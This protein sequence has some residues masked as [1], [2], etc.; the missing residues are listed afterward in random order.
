M[1]SRRRGAVKNKEGYPDPTAGKALANVRRQE[2]QEQK[3][4]KP[5]ERSEKKDVL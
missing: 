3:K 2:K 4:K 1:R 5:K